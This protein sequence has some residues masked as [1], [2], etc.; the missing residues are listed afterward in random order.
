MSGRGASGGWSRAGAG[1]GAAGRRP[2]GQRGSG[3]AHSRPGPA[4]G[5]HSQRPPSGPCA[6]SLHA[7]RGTGRVYA[8]LEASAPE[9]GTPSRS[10]CA[11]C[12]AG[13]GC[14]GRGVDV[15]AG[16]RFWSCRPAPGLVR[17]HKLAQDDW[18]QQPGQAGRGRVCCAADR[19]PG[20]SW[21]GRTGVQGHRA[22][23]RCP[24]ASA[25]GSAVGGG[26][27]RPARMPGASAAWTLFSGPGYGPG[28]AA[29]TGRRSAPRLACCPRPLPTARPGV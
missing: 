21:R 16:T 19:C 27:Q 15:H 6:L 28:A 14:P 1:L 13:A 29:A 20:H 7:R 17:A 22:Q 2:P 9:T 18:R 8:A 12:P 5:H 11:A 26:S 25:R 10:L 3:T 23:G 4:C 24:H